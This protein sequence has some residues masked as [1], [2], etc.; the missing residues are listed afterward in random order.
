MPLPKIDQPTFELKLP[1]TGKKIKYRPF[2]VKEEKILL[3][4]RESKETNDII[5]AIEQVVNNCIVSTDVDVEDFATFDLE[6]VMLNI[7]G[8]AINDVVNF[9]IKD[10]EFEEDVEITFDINE[11]SIVKDEKHTELIDLGND[12]TLK[13]RYPSTKELLKLNGRDDQT[14]VFDAMVSC[15]DVL[16][17]GETVYKFSDFTKKEVD[18][19]IEGLPSSGIEAIRT[20]FTTLPK[21]RIE[22]PYVVQGKEKKFVIEGIETFFM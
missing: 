9:T 11:I 17:H 21:M 14:S 18:D 15:M 5:N 10:P 16:V 1:S 6:Y 20:F 2:T 19:F 13:M 12:F 4:A 8:K 7:R 22:C 3:I